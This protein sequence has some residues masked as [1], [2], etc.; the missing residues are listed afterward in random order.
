MSEREGAKSGPLEGKSGPQEEKS[1]PLTENYGA[2]DK[3]TAT[4]MIPEGCGVD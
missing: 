1:G 2:I 4:E 3:G